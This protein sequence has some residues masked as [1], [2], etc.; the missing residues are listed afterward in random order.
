[1]S[2]PA[3]ILLFDSDRVWLT[4]SKWL[5]LSALRL[6]Q[7][8]T[9]IE[10]TAWWKV[11]VINFDYNTNH[12]FVEVLSYN[13][14]VQPIPD[15]EYPN[16]A[17]CEAIETM[18]F[19]ALKT[20]ELLRTLPAR[21]GASDGSEF[22]NQPELPQPSAR[23]D[24]PISPDTFPLPDPPPQFSDHPDSYPNEP[25]PKQEPLRVFSDTFSVW[26]KNIRFRLGCVAF[27]YFLKPLGINTEVTI[28]NH[29]LR[30]EFDAVKNYFANVLGTKRI[31]VEVRFEVQGTRIVKCEAWSAEIARIN[32]QM[33]DS[34]KFEFVG[35][36]T[37]RK[38][39]VDVD[40]SLFTSEQLFEAL[41]E[42]GMKGRAFYDNDFDLMNDLLQISGTKHYRNLRYLSDRHQHKVM[43]L[44][45]ILR[46]FSF[47]FLLSG[48]RD[49]HLVWETLDTEEATY[50]WHIPQDREKARLMLRKI[51]EIINVV[52]V[53]G[54][55]AYISTASDQYHRIYHD[56]SDLVDGFLK[57]K[58]EL[59]SVL[60]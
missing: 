38:L 29:D 41:T 26:V 36:F 47:I 10:G 6:P 30:E 8:L 35:D 21:H 45:F 5:P 25:T 57:W 37:R 58:A 27:D 4:D 60:T 28:S 18:G 34:V 49:Y 53:Q 40:K 39:R 19:R 52:K 1:M 22:L 51:E 56:Y 48:D 33:I 32:R 31:T 20:F 17:W 9:A 50:V 15:D 2:Q 16:D 14:G 55:T 43:R 42:K 46:P 44:R 3:L 54:K 12:A 24:L 23:P 11:Q 13:K 59:E 7:H